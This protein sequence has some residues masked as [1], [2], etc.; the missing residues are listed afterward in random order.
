MINQKTD[1]LSGSF[2]VFPLRIFPLYDPGSERVVCGFMYD[3]PCSK[4]NVLYYIIFN[5]KL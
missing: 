3:V 4:F 1:H 2:Y 5:I